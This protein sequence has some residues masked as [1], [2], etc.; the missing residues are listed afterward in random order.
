MPP[1]LNLMSLL[2]LNKITVINNL[3]AFFCC[4][5]FINFFPPVS[6]FQIRHLMCFWNLPHYRYLPLTMNYIFCFIFRPGRWHFLTRSAARISTSSPGP[7]CGS[8]RGRVRPL[9]RDSWPP[10]P[11]GCWQTS[12][13]TSPSHSRRHC[14]Q[15]CCWE[16]LP[17]IYRVTC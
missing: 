8:W 6:A 9:P 5:Y 4:C 17:I 1:F 10:P 16:I 3:R 14:S 11:G 13:S 7:G 15:I 12:T 2:N